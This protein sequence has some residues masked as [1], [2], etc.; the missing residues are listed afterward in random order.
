MQ[1]MLSSTFLLWPQN[2]DSLIKHDEDLA[3]LQSMK[4]DRVASFGGLDKKL[5]QKIVRRNCRN[6]S[7]LQRLQRARDTM[8]TSTAPLP[9]AAL[10]DDS[11]TDESSEETSG[12]DMEFGVQA[13]QVKCF[14]RNKKR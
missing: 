7:A 8:K 4:G 10:S 6:A 14:H 9:S 3:F 11:D 5:A 12:D 2:A 13:N 1:A